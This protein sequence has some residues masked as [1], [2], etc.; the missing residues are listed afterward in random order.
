LLQDWPF[1]LLACV[2]AIC[3]FWRHST[4]IS[5]LRQGTESKISLGK[6]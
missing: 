5:R 3:L 2:I 6:K 4:N 1:V